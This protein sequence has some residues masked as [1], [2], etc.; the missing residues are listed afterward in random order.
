[1]KWQGQQRWQWRPP[2]QLPVAGFQSFLFAAANLSIFSSDT[3]L[4][5][6]IVIQCCLIDYLQAHSFSKVK[7]KTLVCCLTELKT[8]NNACLL[9]FLLFSWGRIGKPVFFFDQDKIFH[10][11]ELLNS[12]SG[13]GDEINR[14]N[15]F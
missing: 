1:M 9:N 12:V 4:K 7:L 10:L 5:Y 3:T 2:A 6:I 14:R 15:K 11:L 13:P 8:Q